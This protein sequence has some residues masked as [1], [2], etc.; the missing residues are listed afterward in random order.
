MAVLPR[1][2]RLVH[3]VAALQAG[4]ECSADE[5][6]AV[7]VERAADVFHVAPAV[8]A[9]PVE[10]EVFLQGAAEGE[11]EGETEGETEGENVQ[12]ELAKVAVSGVS[13]RH[14]EKMF[15][16]QRYTCQGR[17]STCLLGIAKQPMNTS[18]QPTC[19]QPI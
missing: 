12:C 6:D 18:T 4:L 3:L 11:A 2:R 9:E 1:Q 10:A 7:A 17:V 19:K 16:S 13:G 5:A 14:G 15:I 8:F